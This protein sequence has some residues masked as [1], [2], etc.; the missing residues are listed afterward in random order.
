MT[1]QNF[2]SAGRRWFGHHA[3]TVVRRSQKILEDQPVWI[4]FLI[5]LGLSSRKTFICEKL[6]PFLS[7]LGISIF[8]DGRY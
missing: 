6:L 4:R 8:L 2:V 7:S 3:E 5:C 1:R